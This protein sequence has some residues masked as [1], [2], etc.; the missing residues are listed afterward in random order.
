MTEPHW[1]TGETVD[2][3]TQPWIMGMN[4][5]YFLLG[6]KSLGIFLLIFII[7]TIN[8]LALSVSLQCNKGKPKL[9]SGLYAF[10]FGPIYLI[11]NYYSVRL[12]TEG[13]SCEFSTENPF[14]FT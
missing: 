13:K 12:M 7:L 8:F 11:V 6:V 3:N 10:F 1:L 14:P 4:R 9:L 5:S 2:E